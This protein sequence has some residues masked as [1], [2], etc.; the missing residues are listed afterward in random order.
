MTQ[1]RSIRSICAFDIPAEGDPVAIE[2]PWPTATKA[3]G[4]AYRWLHFDLAE[5][6]LEAWMQDFLPPI[7]SSSLRQDETRPRFGPFADGSILNLRGVN[8]NEGATPE[9]MVSIRLWVSDGLI[10]SARHRKIWAVDA[11]RQRVA[12]GDAPRSTGRFLA[13]LA[14]GL[15]RRIEHVSIALEEQTDDLEERAHEQ[16][17]GLNEEVA[18][19]RQRAIKLRRYIRPQREALSDMIESRNPSFD[20]HVI[21]LLSET[22]NR[23]M[24]TIEA[25]DATHERLAAIQDLL[26]IQHSKALGRN[27]YVLSIVAAIFLPL[28]F[29]T[30]LFGINVGGMP[31]ISS[32][33]GFWIVTGGLTV[34]GIVLFFLFR[35]L[36]WL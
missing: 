35:H 20:D 24:R 27:S 32:D 7:A 8:L 19:C 17:D 33:L 1:P 15:T 22:A 31:L 14:Y 36:R 29:V 5:P 4:M 26:D 12:A 34:L 18:R 9:D 6:E 3:E 30:G 10:V 16:A 13:D 25:L 28:G 2:T 23:V 11:I 21:L